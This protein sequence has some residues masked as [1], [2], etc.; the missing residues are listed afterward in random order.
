MTPDQT[1][2]ISQVREVIADQPQVIFTQEDPPT[3]AVL[4]REFKQLNGRNIPWIGTDVTSGSDFLKA[5]GYS[6]AH[7]VLTSVYGTS[8]TGAANTAFIASSTSS[9]RA[10]RR[11]ARWPTPTTPTTR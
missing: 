6:T 9:S 4:F 8:V 11:P 3:A 7:A 5:I 10:R 1:S 2:Y